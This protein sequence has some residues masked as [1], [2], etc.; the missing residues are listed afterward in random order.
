MGKTK[1]KAR[2]TRN[3][4]PKRLLAALSYTK[5]SLVFLAAGFGLLLLF[6]F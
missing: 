4:T 6:I 3:E 1:T 5:I 2:K